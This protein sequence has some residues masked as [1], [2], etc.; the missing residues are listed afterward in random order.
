MVVAVAAAEVGAEGEVVNV[1]WT[2]AGAG[3]SVP[4]LRSAVTLATTGE[5]EAVARP[6]A[7]GAGS[8]AGG[9]GRHPG[10]AATERRRAAG[11]AGAGG[12]A[13]AVAG[14]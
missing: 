7:A 13:A 8:L 6:P 5:S 4:G 2:M 12:G 11:V 10:G 1:G 3:A 14:N 9:G